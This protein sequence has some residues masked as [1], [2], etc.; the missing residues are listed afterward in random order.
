MYHQ[1]K[2]SPYQ[3]PVIPTATA[4]HV[5]RASA[6]ERKSRGKRILLT[7][8]ECLYFANFEKTSTVWTHC[9]GLF[10]SLRKTCAKKGMWTSASPASVCSWSH[11]VSHCMLILW[12][13]H[14]WNIDMATQKQIMCCKSSL[15]L[16]E[17][18]NFPITVSKLYTWSHIPLSLQGSLTE[19]SEGK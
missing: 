11:F 19:L 3:N 2:T 1:L 4:T 12:A 7:E 13:T 8:G 6:T 5:T 16:Q 17:K 15:L 9:W 10:Q 18:K 14:G